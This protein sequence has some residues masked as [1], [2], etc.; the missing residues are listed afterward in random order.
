[1]SSTEGGDGVCF[2]KSHARDTLIV[3]TYLYMCA[4]VSV[5]DGNSVVV[6]GI[7]FPRLLILGRWQV[8]SFPP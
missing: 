8:L 7:Y 5:L 6:R 4:R 3:C 1:M 2:S